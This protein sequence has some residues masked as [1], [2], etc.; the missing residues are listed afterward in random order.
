MFSR[1]FGQT[2][3]KV[4]FNREALQGLASPPELDFVLVRK[5]NL[6]VNKGSDLVDNPLKKLL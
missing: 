1:S 5:T 6:V 2:E 4:M 3:L